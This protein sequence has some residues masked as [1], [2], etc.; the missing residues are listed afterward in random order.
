MQY[1]RDLQGGGNWGPH[2]TTALPPARFR[3]LRTRSLVRRNQAPISM[4][5]GAWQARA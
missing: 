5:L 3:A 4:W 2:L 1:L